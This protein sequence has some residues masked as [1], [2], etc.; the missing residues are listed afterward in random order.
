MSFLWWCLSIYF[1]FVSVTQDRMVD[2]L[3]AVSVCPFFATFVIMSWRLFLSVKIG[4]LSSQ[5]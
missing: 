1:S 5:L 2:M 4:F 3:A